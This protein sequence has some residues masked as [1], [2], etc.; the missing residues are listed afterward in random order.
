MAYDFQRS[1]V[2]KTPPEQVYDYLLQIPRHKEW[3]DMETL[4][5]L[6]EGPAQ[7]GSQWRSTGRT[8]AFVM[9]DECTITALV[10]P[11]L[12]SFKVFSQA[13]AG[14]GEITLSYEL[15]PVPDG[16]KVTFCRE[17]HSSEMK[18]VMKMMMAIPGMRQLMDSMVT[19]KAVDE[20]LNNLR[21]RLENGTV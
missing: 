6:Y 12:I 2:I 20:G 4:E 9:H 1:I 19:A 13:A 7:V 11:S 10:R 3:G 18:P 21:E 5:I 15:E 16:T 14:S 17:T 8:A